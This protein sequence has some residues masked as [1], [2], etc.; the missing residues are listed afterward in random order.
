MP[1]VE[2]VY[3]KCYLSA[4]AYYDKVKLDKIHP[5]FLNKNI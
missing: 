2:N 3:W 4:G 5:V 1:C